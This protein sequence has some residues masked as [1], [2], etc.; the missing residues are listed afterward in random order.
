MKNRILACLSAA[1][2]LSGCAHTIAIGPD[3]AKIERD[4]TAQPIKKSVGYYISEESRNL[5]VTTPGGGGDKVN[6]RPYK[7]TET[8]FYKMLTNVFDNVAVLQL[9]NDAEAI[10]KNK[11]SYIIT[12]QLVTNSSSSSALTWPPTDFTVDMT[13]TISDA[14]GNTVA[15]KAVNGQGKA[16]FS[17]F[18]S[19]FSLS[20]KRASEDALL[21]MQR[22][23]LAET[24][25]LRK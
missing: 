8:A 24:P 6:Y 11:V 2:L 1:I 15:T 23:L 14:A 7:D 13:C 21:K 22:A 20:G 18:K 19:D 5:E 25:E 17:E 4:A 12:P 3:V 10:S 9:P 16:E